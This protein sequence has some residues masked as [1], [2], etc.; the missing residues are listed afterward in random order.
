MTAITGRIGSGKS[1]LLRV[2]LGLLPAQ[3]GEVRWNGVV[4]D[5]PAE[6]FVPP[7]A[8]YVSQVP[9]LFSYSVRENVLLGHPGGDT[10]VTA[11]L[12][13]ASIGDEVAGFHD[14][15]DTVVGPRGVRLSGGQVQRTAAAR[16]FLRRPELL[17][18]DDLSSALDVETEARLWRQLL[19]SGST[20]TLV[21]VSHR[22]AVLERAD[23]VVE[24]Y[25][26]QRR[27]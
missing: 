3:S 19:D 23:Q 20:T 5:R 21:V 17:I 2:L 12:S 13:A 26:G 9:Q 1:T 18:L 4:V 6:F 16:A 10:E 24:L 15:L 7:H 25:G 14:G 11:A 27:R 8:A 22:A